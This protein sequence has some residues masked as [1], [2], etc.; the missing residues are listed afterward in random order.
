MNRSLIDQWSIKFLL[1]A[2]FSFNIF[3]KS[4]C[5]AWPNCDRSKSGKLI[6]QKAGK[7][8]YFVLILI[9]LGSEVSVQMEQEDLENQISPASTSDKDLPFV[10]D[11]EP[12]KEWIQ[13]KE[14]VQNEDL[15]KLNKKYFNV[16]Q[17]MFKK[18]SIY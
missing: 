13:L 10:F 7:L 11:S 17:G 6:L 18:T 12:G 14:V 2:L 3:N 1:K 9:I 5:T 8:I 15:G 16:N 4:Q